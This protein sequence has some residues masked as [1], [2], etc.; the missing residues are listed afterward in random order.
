MAKQHIGCVSLLVGDYEE[1]KAWYC[2]V[3]GFMVVEDTPLPAGKRSR[4]LKISTGT[5]GTSFN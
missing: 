4:F 1:A 5:A 3:L 2:D